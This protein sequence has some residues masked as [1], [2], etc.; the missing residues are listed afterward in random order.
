M[1]E[2]NQLVFPNMVESFRSES[3]NLYERRD[4]FDKS[5]MSF[6][7]AKPEVNRDI[8]GSKLPLDLWTMFSDF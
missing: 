2:L 8:E 5:E 7:T 4:S 3:V 6:V 1:N